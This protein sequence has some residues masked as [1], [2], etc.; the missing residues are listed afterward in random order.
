MSVGVKLRKARILKEID[1]PWLAEKVK[2]SQGY[3][4][5]I[6]NEQTSPRVDLLIEWC[7]LLDVS[8]SDIISDQKSTQT[9][10]NS[11]LKQNAIGG[12]MFNFQILSPDDAQSVIKL[13]QSVINK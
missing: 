6:E 1:Q 9:I 10:N 13:V 11:E 8:P 12:V 3:I 2:V 5:Q 4:S 7:K